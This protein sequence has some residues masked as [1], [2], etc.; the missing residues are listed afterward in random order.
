MKLIKYL[1]T[2]LVASFVMAGTPASA[3]NSLTS[4]GVTFEWASAGSYLELS[5]RDALSGPTSTDNWDE[6]T[7]LAAF[8]IGIDG[9]TGATVTDPTGWSTSPAELNSM[10]CAGGG[11]TN[12]FCFETA[13]PLALTDDLSFNIGLTGVDPDSVAGVHIK[14]AFID[15]VTYD[16][17]FDTNSDLYGTWKDN[18]E[19]WKATGDLLSM[20]VPVPEPE[21]YA[22]MAVGMGI[23]GWA[24]RRKK[25]KQAV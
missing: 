9:L 4:Q 16:T 20:T 10:G 8:Q 23:M 21:I 17:Y 7:H 22:M 15:Q 1:L 2:A 19:D 11:S 3:A 5:I 12:H 6:I 25:R 13:D 24:A 14:V 18:K